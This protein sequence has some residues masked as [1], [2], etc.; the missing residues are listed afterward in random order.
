M[1]IKKNVFINQFLKILKRDLEEKLPEQDYESEMIRKG[2]EII[3]KKIKH[4]K[5]QIEEV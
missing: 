1:I 3:Y 4:I 5:S 2:W